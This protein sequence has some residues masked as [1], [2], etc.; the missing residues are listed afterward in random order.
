MPTLI[1]GA[2]AMQGL[3][4]GQGR[5][6]PGHVMGAVPRSQ[7]SCIIREEILEIYRRLLLNPIVFS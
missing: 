6:Q 7:Y 2:G 1:S 3:D 5:G 4:G